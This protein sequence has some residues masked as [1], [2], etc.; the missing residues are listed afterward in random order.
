MNLPMTS[1]RILRTL[2]IAGFA[3]ILLTTSLSYAALE[4]PI[5]DLTEAS[6]KAQA[7]KDAGRSGNTVPAH[8]DMEAKLATNFNFGNC[9]VGA[10]IVCGVGV[11]TNDIPGTAPVGTNI[12]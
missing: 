8:W 3:V 12:A 4:D 1:R 6:V 11:F 7:E 5:F 9:D 2:L 10:D